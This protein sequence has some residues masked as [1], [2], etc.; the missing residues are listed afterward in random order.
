MSRWVHAMLLRQDRQQETG[1]G[2]LWLSGN[3]SRTLAAIA[4]SLSPERV[5]NVT[6]PPS[7]WT[8]GLLYQ[9]LILDYFPIALIS[10][11]IKPK[12]IKIVVFKNYR[13]LIMYSKGFN[14]FS[15]LIRVLN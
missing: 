2:D 14:L 8:P 9:E 6:M 7:Y 10:R 3:A 5:K 11:L 15:I 4:L 13:F 1:S 12:A